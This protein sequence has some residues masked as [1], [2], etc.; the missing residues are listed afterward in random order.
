M[1]A[2]S[3]D[4]GG[5]RPTFAALEKLTS[6]VDRETCSAS[7]LP[8]GTFTVHVYVNSERAAR[9]SRVT[10]RTPIDV[11]ERSAIEAVTAALASAGIPTLAAHGAADLEIRTPG[12]E[13]LELVV[14]AAS[15]VD[16]M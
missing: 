5:S 13:T 2:A 15:R 9:V 1:V 3:T 4:G 11:L 12:G 7:S 10:Q 14:K 6:A 16:P 8:G